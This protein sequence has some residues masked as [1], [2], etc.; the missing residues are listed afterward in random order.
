MENVH[1]F[2]ISR[3]NIVSFFNNFLRLE[4]VYSFDFDVVVIVL[5]LNISK[6]QK[7]NIHATCV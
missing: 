4:K 2:C 3:I 7:P 5:I 6:L 1:F